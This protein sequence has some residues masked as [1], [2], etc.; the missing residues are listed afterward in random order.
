MVVF[1]TA[2]YLVCFSVETNLF[3]SSMCSGFIKLNSALMVAQMKLL[4]NSEV[5]SSH[6]ITHNDLQTHEDNKGEQCPSR[7]M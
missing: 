1:Q 4:Y 7:V 3:L 2:E 6:S 5:V